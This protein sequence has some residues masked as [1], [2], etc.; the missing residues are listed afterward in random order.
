MNWV[1]RVF[2]QQGGKEQVMLV[3]CI[4]LTC[5]SALLWCCTINGCHNVISLLKLVKKLCRQFDFSSIISIV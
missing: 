1:V 2:K 3:K 4:L 5:S